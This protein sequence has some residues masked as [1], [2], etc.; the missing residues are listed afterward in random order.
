MDRGRVEPS[1]AKVSV[2]SPISEPS[3]SETA[4]VVPAGGSRIG[5]SAPGAT[6]AAQESS[7][8]KPVCETRVAT[9]VY[10]RGRTRG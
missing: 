8:F 4:R 7:V 1:L 3:R 2:S 10:S 6:T 9:D 5:V